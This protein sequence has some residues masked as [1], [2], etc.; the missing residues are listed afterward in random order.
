MYG[1]LT[2]FLP[3]R[4]ARRNWEQPVVPERANTRITAACLSESDLGCSGPAASQPVSHY[5]VVVTAQPTCVPR[6]EQTPVLIS[7]ILI[8]IISQSLLAVQV[9]VSNS[10]LDKG[11]SEDWGQ[12]G[13]KPPNVLS[14]LG[15]RQW[16]NICN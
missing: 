9:I 13:A 7:Q 5:V 11:L 6:T 10:S 16:M 15:A 8:K 4:S 2:L 12:K 14:C 1:L 3:G